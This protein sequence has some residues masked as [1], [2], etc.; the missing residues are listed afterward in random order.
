MQPQ[1]EGKNATCPV[2]GGTGYRTVEGEGH[3]GYAAP[4]SCRFERYATARLARAR[5]PPQYE[6]ATFETFQVRRDDNPLAGR[7]CSKIFVEV[8]GWV[9]DFSP[10]NRRG[11]LIT[12]PPGT[13]KSHLAAAALKM[14]ISKGFDGLFWDYQSLLSAIARTWNKYSDNPDRDVY[15]SVISADLLVIDDL[16]AKRALEWAEDIIT[17]IITMRYN[18]TKPLIVTTNLPLDPT[19]VTGPTGFARVSRHL[20]EVIGDRSRSRLIEMCR[21]VDTSSLD[22]YRVRLARRT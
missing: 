13:G 5:I 1:T 7:A 6:N 12:G 2:C 20:G 9:R 4:C 8:K 11:L 15:E 16:G 10:A 14:A 18:S 21:V 17:D 3:V 22:D 19:P